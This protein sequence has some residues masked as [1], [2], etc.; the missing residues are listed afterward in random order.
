MTRWAVERGP[1]KRERGERAGLLVAGLVWID[2]SRAGPSAS[3]S[4]VA[5]PDDVERDAVEVDRRG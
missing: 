3:E 5:R 1:G 2:V 4:A